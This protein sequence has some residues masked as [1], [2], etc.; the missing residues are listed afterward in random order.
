MLPLRRARTEWDLLLWGYYE[1][2][3]AELPAH[4]SGTIVR[5][6]IRARDEDSGQTDLAHD[7]A[8]YS[9]IVGDSGPP[10]WALP[11]I[12]YQIFPDRFSPG[13]GPWLEPGGA[14]LRHLRRHVARRH[15]SS[16][17]YRRIGF[18][19]P[20][21]STRFSPTTLITAITPPIISPSTRAWGRWTTC[22]NW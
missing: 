7:G 8:E 12:I 22:A 13:I 2:W 20:L 15:R 21:G 5:Y 17:L 9:Y 18:H 3:E 10:A 16:R 6:Q 4:P 19:S 1:V 14:S 11:A